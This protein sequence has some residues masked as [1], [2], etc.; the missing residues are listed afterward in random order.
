MGQYLAS[1]QVRQL[2]LP[3]RPRTRHGDTSWPP[4]GSGT[5]I[6]SHHNLDESAATE[7]TGERRPRHL[8]SIVQ[9]VSGVGDEARTLLLPPFSY[10]P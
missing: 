8:V 7:Q 5:W 4:G 9:V 10:S 1:R 6:L 3:T 2:T